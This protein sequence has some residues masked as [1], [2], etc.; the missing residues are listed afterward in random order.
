MNS[1]ER[2]LAA[3]NHKE[4]DRVPVDMVLTM[5]TNMQCLVWFRK[6]LMLVVKPRKY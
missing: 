5:E 6:L 3:L 2:V 1:R 4:P